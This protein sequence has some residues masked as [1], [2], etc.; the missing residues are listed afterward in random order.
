[1]SITNRE[2]PEQLKDQQK[3]LEN[4]NKYGSNLTQEVLENGTE[5]IYGRD[6]EIDDIIKI[7]ARKKKNNVVLVGEP[8]TGK[9]HIVTGLVLRI[10]EQKVPKDMDGK[11]VYSLD[12]G[13]IMA[14]TKYRGE[15]EERLRNILREIE[16]NGNIILFIDEIHTI[17][18]GESGNSVSIANLLKPYL[19]TGKIKVI[20]ATTLDEYKK[21]FEKDGAMTRRFNKIVVD[22]PTLDAC[23]NILRNISNSYSK[24]H[25]VE[26]E[27][28]I[29]AE[30][31][32]LAKKYIRDKFLPDSA[33]DVL[34]ELGAKIKVESQSS[35]YSTKY[36]KLKAEFDKMMKYR[37]V[38]IKEERYDEVAAFMAKK[39]KVEADLNNEKIANMEKTSIA[40]KI[41][42]EDLLHTISKISQIPL[43]K[44]NSDG[45]KNVKKLEEI[46]NKKLIN[47]DEAKE[48]V[49][50]AIKR[51]VLGLENPNKPKSFLFVG[52]SGGG[53][54]YLA[55]LIADNWFDGSMVRIDMSEYQE[56]I[57]STTLIGSPPGYVGY[58]QGGTLTEQVRRKPYSLVLID[59][60]EKAHP[61]ILNLLL[62]I[63]DEGHVTD[64]Q[65]KKVDFKNTIIVMTSNLGAKASEYIPVG[66]NKHAHAP[67]V[68]DITLDA[69]KSHF[70]P[71]LWN[72]IDSVIT[73]NPLTK[74][75]MDSI[76]KIEMDDISSLIKSKYSLKVN[77]SKKLKEILVD[78]GFDK[79]LGARPLK[80]AV[81]N[82]IMDV[83]SDYI[84]DND[85]SENTKMNLD[86]NEE[87][88]KAVCVCL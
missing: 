70:R 19:T 24:F 1:M 22:E 18:G 78:K 81:E 30:I 73:F 84:I 25:N 54:T 9:T 20:G 21:H 51:K 17:M 10:L 72:R 11:I 41:T 12:S 33:I 4:L 6:N 80:R 26:F 15:M 44:L 77:F 48:K 59:E 5:S 16:E 46:L 47:Q 53:K 45:K 14:G 85:I 42:R 8:G 13:S 82:I 36:K 52:Q 67:K 32:V 60:I 71:E 83:V 88:G 7:L 65:G 43:D 55:K 63:L 23:V 64:N 58:E 49:I 37:V 76:L 69:C 39:K 66:F 61:D 56:K 3:P 62:Q 38:L 27:D 29:L 31:P 40:V 28:S 2:S 86:W 50:K 87:S 57:A 68:E 74:L 75:D 35:L 79:N 34:D